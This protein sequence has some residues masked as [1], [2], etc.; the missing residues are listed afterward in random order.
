MKSLRFAYFISVVF[1]LMLA[2][3]SLI[4]YR[5]RMLFVD[6]A[7]ITFEI[8]NSGWFVF[9]EHRYGAWITQLF[10]LIGS[11]LGISLRGILIGYSM[12]FYL[13]YLIVIYVSGHILKQYKL[14]ILFC[15]YLTMMVSD[16]YFW[17]N[18]EVHQAIGWMTMFL[19]LWAWTVSRPRRTP[20][21]MH[22]LMITTLFFATISHLLV[23]I[24]LGFIWL[25][26]NTDYLIRYRTL[27][28]KTIIYSVL[29]LM[30]IGFRYWLSSESWYD[31][32]K[33][34][35]VQN[36]SLSSVLDAIMNAQGKSMI[37]LMLTHYWSL[38][39]LLVIGLWKVAVAKQW[40]KV[41]L[42]FGT[43]I[44]FYLLVT[45]TH[46]DAITTQNLFYFESQWMGL[47]IILA[48]PF[49]MEYLPRLQPKIIAWI[50]V[51]IFICQVPK[52]YQSY[53]KFTKRLDIIESLVV[54]AKN[55]ASSKHYILESQ[56]DQEALLMTWGL[57]IE[58]LLFSI[59]DREYSP[60]TIKNVSERSHM[61]TS[62]D[63]IHTAFKLLKSTQ[64]NERYFELGDERYMELH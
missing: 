49:V 12:S 64:L 4:F 36:T 22:A 38:L 29:M 46:S 58:T 50:M 40:M 9:S 21:W 61:T 32:N 41:G 11:K 16:V 10:P 57:P 30:G 2:T 44:V 48:T 56:L 6:P 26:M 31:G 33:L 20:L 25:Y 35:G 52:L 54:N 19:S 55:H 24:P 43:S 17:P 7:F 51:L 59:I 18:N 8:I 42:V 47:S 53:S 3:G 13:F 63:S 34:D 60:L 5:E 28:N 37:K 1:I 15:L 23:V 27:D 62:T 45:L 14:A 39:I